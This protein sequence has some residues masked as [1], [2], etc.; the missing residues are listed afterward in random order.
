MHHLSGPATITGP[1]TGQRTCSDLYVRRYVQGP[2]Y[3]QGHSGGAYQRPS[4]VALRKSNT[5]GRKESW[6]EA[7]SFAESCSEDR[8][9]IVALGPH[10]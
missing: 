3:L 8:A 6:A 5:R 4:P 7:G 9:R 10:C 2:V 1:S